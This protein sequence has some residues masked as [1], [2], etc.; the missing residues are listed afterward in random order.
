MMMN[1]KNAVKH[2]H[3]PTRS[4]V[5]CRDNAPKRELTRLVVSGNGLE[6]DPSGKQTGRGAYLCTKA[7]C[8]ERAAQTDALNKALRTTLSDTDRQRLKQA[9]P[10][11]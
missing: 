8:W 1:G 2:K 5:I 7:D 6:I 9:Q 3:I 4:C 11:L 10:T